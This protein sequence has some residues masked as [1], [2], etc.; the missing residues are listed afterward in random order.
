MDTTYYEKLQEGAT[1][2]NGVALSPAATNRKREHTFY[3]VGSAGVAAGAV[4]I[5]TAP[6]QDYGG[7]WAPLGNAVTVVAST[8]AIVQ[9]TGALLAVRAR[10]STNISSGT[11]SVVYV[12]N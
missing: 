6:S 12:G 7:T 3:I 1:T 2:G 5:E 11:V 10:V 8:A 4:Q 9:V